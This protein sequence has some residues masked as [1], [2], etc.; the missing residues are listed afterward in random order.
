MAEE[1]NEDCLFQFNH[2]WGDEWNV[3]F[4]YVTKDLN[5]FTAFWS[6]FVK[7]VN[8]RHP[9]SFAAIAKY[10]QAH[11]DNIYVIRNQY[12]AVPEAGE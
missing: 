6:E 2:A 10:F 12:Q 5:S 3:N 11:K 9:G 4:W 1:R 7:R 8:E